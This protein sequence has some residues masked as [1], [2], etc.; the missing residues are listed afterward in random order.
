M[1]RWR[2]AQWTFLGLGVLAWAIGLTLGPRGLPW[3]VGGTLPFLVGMVIFT[4]L[5]AGA[6]TA[7]ALA[8]CLLLLTAAVALSSLSG[9]AAVI[10]GLLFP[11]SL[12]LLGG[13][14]YWLKIGKARRR[15]RRL[16]ATGE[17]LPAVVRGVDRQGVVVEVD[18]GDPRHAVAIRVEVQPPGRPPFTATAEAI[19]GDDELAH[20]TEGRQ[21]TVRHDPRE[22]DRVALDL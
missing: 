21:V 17:R 19:L 1:G 10:A 6:M 16:L 4:G 13:W 15:N 7:L 20:L 3:L 5:T 11:A 9:T 12:V 22:P 14:I 18:G 2:V 8:V